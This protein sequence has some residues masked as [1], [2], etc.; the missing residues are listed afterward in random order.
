[1]GLAVS[2]TI[3]GKQETIRKLSKLGQSLILNKPMMES[4]GKELTAFFSGQVY[5]SQGGAIG[6]RWPRLSPV[7]MKQ[8]LKKF[9]N[10][11]A[12]LIAT[13]DMQKSYKFEADNNQVTIYNDA[14]QFPYHQS[15]QPRKTNLPRRATMAV[16]PEVK[17][18]IQS[19]VDAGVSKKIKDAGL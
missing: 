9:P 17:S 8:K 15:K 19:V 11:A 16:N 14:P 6:E 7:Y 4:I 1:M 5:A 2:V 12:I 3:S 13:G 18:I 10:A